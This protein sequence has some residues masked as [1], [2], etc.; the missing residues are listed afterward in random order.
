[1]TGMENVFNTVFEVLKIGNLFNQSYFISFLIARLLTFFL[2]NFPGALI[3]HFA[4]TMT[5]TKR[6]AADRAI[7]SGLSFTLYF[8]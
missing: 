4:I 7:S 6:S 2:G 1:M 5:R 8:C 3:F